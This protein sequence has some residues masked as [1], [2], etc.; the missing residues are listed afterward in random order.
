MR[1]GLFTAA[2]VCLGAVVAA[3]FTQLVLGWEPCVMC[4]EVRAA[5]IAAGLCFVGGGLASNR[6]F[7]RVAMALGVF[8]SLWASKISIQLFALEMGYEESFGCSPF[9]DFPSWMPLN[10]WLPIIF[11][12]QG[13]CGDAVKSI[14]Y[15]PLSLWTPIFVVILF[16]VF[17]KNRKHI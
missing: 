9:A 1:L 8:F 16:V 2:A 10:E 6:A 11:E 7:R 13:V 12:P 4:V 15:V 5:L 3:M 14:G 17:Y